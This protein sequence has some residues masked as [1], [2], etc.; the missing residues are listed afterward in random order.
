MTNC[1]ICTT[2][3]ST[4]SLSSPS[5]GP[6]PSHSLTR[7]WTAVSV[8]SDHFFDVVINPSGMDCWNTEAKYMLQPANS[9]NDL[10]DEDDEPVSEI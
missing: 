6:G 7:P 3:V 9:D 5:P 4:G 10:L 8:A 1:Y 2:V